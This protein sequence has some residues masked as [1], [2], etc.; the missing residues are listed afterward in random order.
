MPQIGNM[1]DCVWEEEEGDRTN[2][3]HEPGDKCRGGGDST[4]PST[5]LVVVVTVV[6]GRGT[7]LRP[8]HWF[9]SPGPV[10]AR[11]SEQEHV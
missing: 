11:S 2:M 10:S 3:Q 6:A 9:H 8:P 5:W 4:S 1:M 7:A